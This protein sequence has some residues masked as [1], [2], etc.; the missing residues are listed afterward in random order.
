MKEAAYRIAQEALHNIVKHAQATRVDIRLTTEDGA[1][2]LVVQ[3]NGV[4]FDSGGAF[5]GHIGLR[6]MRERTAKSNGTIEITSAPGAGTCITA[7]L[8]I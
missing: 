8:R 7:R 4:G 2:T 1:L 6:S 3:D 5:P